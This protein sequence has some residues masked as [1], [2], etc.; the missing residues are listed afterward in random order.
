[1]DDITATVL[2]ARARQTGN[3]VCGLTELSSNSRIVA[4]YGFVPFGRNQWKSIC[5]L[6]PRAWTH[7]PLSWGA[8]AAGST[9]LFGGGAKWFG[10]S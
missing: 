1:M 7:D 6:R 10:I 3:G 5:V 8:G 9:Q 4:P 2:I